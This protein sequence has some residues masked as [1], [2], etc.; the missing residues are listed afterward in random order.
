M[1]ETWCGFYK[2]A[3]DVILA[4]I[5]KFE[6]VICV[7]CWLMEFGCKKIVHTVR[8]ELTLI[9]QLGFESNAFDRSAMCVCFCSGVR[10]RDG[11]ARAS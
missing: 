10:T 3:D 8:F 9:E 1:H 5:H 2:D 11:K 6:L 4:K 7:L